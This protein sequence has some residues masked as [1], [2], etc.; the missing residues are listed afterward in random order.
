MNVVVQLSPRIGP[1]VCVSRTPLVSCPNLIALI[2][3]QIQMKL[4]KYSEILAQA[5]LNFIRLQVIILLIFLNKSGSQL[6]SVSV[7]ISANQYFA[8]IQNFKR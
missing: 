5:A 3:L 7:L 2:N 8:P 1:I 4:K 6:D